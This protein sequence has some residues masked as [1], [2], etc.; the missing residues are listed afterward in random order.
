MGGNLWG[1][2][3]SVGSMHVLKDRSGERGQM[4][5]YDRLVLDELERDTSVQDGNV[6]AKRGPEGFL[7]FSVVKKGK[8]AASHRVCDA[9]CQ[10]LCGEDFAEGGSV[11]W[12]CEFA[13]QETGMDG[14]SEDECKHSTLLSKGSNVLFI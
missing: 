9:C 2:T 11:C 14:Q 10:V 8:V 3:D 5:G 6:V 1:F 12:R 7:E 13:S 4:E